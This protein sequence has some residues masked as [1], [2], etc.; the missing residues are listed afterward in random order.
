MP[1]LRGRWGWLIWLVLLVAAALAWRVPNLDAFSLS[2]DEG[3]HLTWAWLLHEGHPLYSETV[4]VWTPLL[5]VLLD[6]AYDLLG[7]GV[8]SGRAL[9]L[10]FLVLACAT[11]AWSAW[12]FYAQEDEPTSWLAVLVTILVF[13][14]AP[15]VFRLSRMAMGEVP[16][17]ALAIFA[18]AL[19]QMYARRSTWIWLL[20]SGLL[21][22]M[23]LLVKAVNP[24]IVL[25]II[26]LVVTKPG[27]ASWRSRIARMAVWGAAALVPL[28][29]C[30]VFY[31]PIAFYDQVVAFRLQ[32]RSVYPLQIERNLFQLV[33]FWRQHWGIVVLAVC[34]GVLL[35][36]RARWRTLIPLGLWLVGGG[37]LPLI[38]HS[39]LFYQHTIILL[40]QLALL[41]GGAA[42]TWQLLRERRWLWGSLGAISAIVLIWSV[43]GMVWAN[44]EVLQARF[45]REAEAV[46]LLQRVTR[47]DD[48]VI[49]DNLMLTFMAQRKPP[50]PFG[51]L[52]QVAIDS[53]RQTSRRL[54]ALSETYRV[55]AVANWALRLPQLTEYMEWVECHYLVRRAWD[56][57]HVLYFARKVT[58]NEVPQRRP[59]MFEEGIALV[60]FDAQLDE[61]ATWLRVTV[62][63]QA[64]RALRRDLTVFVHL[65]DAAGRLVASHDGQPVYG[66]LP[67]TRWP[68]DELIPDRHDFPLPADLPAGDYVLTTGLY[69]P[70]NGTRLAVTVDGQAVDQR[71]VTLTTISISR[72]LSQ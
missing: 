27:Q 44:N 3:A 10:A 24:L 45:G 13:M 16:A 48:A 53:G 4:L 35:A 57:H 23:S 34:G 65:Y 29:L 17:V 43:P 56:D 39:P 66:Y 15:I 36:R 72:A 61:A 67:T 2:N 64:M 52:A 11:L 68:V 40:P 62:F 12:L 60:G 32:L 6:W 28:A 21:Y 9:V 1:M 63:W 25:L 71:A 59:A 54:I 41:C 49:S 47:P 22:S 20:F 51:D 30:F 46:T 18:V 7:V 14:L 33:D 31:D 69:D 70:V 26:W 55:E 50:P 58:A 19:A 8:V 38:I 42:A 5:F 37:I